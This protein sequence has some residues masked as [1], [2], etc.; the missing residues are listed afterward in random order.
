MA[1]LRPVR[2]RNAPGTAVAPL[3]TGRERIIRQGQAACVGKTIVSEDW[4]EW[5]CL[6]FMLEV[7]YFLM[8]FY[9]L[10]V[11][12]F[13]RWSCICRL[14]GLRTLTGHLNCC[15]STAISYQLHF[16]HWRKWRLIC[17]LILV[18]K[19]AYIVMLGEV[20]QQFYILYILLDYVFLHNNHETMLEVRELNIKTWIAGTLTDGSH[21]PLACLKPLG[22][23]SFQ[24]S[25]LWL[26]HKI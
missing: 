15:F 21:A 5:H 19:E 23:Q 22:S 16:L 26:D 11:S 13:L 20:N 1:S 7:T 14:P 8:I 17:I 25:I 24:I 6:R 9:V 12:F 10:H 3:R 4:R 18:A 2:P